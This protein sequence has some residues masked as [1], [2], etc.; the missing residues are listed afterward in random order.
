MEKNIYNR[1]LGDLTNFDDKRPTYIIWMSCFTLSILIT[2]ILTFADFSKHD[3]TGC[4][5]PIDG[6]EHGI[7][8]GGE[9]KEGK[10]ISF[11]VKGVVMRRLVED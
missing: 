5:F 8:C 1:E 10:V 11:E 7:T 2:A 4:R 6:I 3:C 9:L